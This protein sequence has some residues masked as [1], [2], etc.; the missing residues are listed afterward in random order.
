M[1]RPSVLLELMLEMVSDKG[2][3]MIIL[4]KWTCSFSDGQVRAGLPTW[5]AAL[6]PLP[7]QRSRAEGQLP[8]LEK[9]YTCL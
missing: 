8:V 2:I 6:V 4:Q 3:P 9:I 7:A 1:E 5:G